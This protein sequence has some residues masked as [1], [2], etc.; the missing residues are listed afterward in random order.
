MDSTDVAV[1]GAGPAGM[2][3]AA[4]AAIHG[5]SVVLL[6]EQRAAGGQ[7]YRAVEAAAGPRGTLLGKDYREGLKLTVALANVA[8]D[9]RRDATVWRL[10]PDGTL[11]YSINGTARLLRARRII[12]ATG[13]LERPVPIPGWTLPGVMTAGA[14][15]I[16]MKE[17]GLVPER[18]VI[19]GCGPLLYL[20]AWQMIR[21]GRPPHALVETQRSED[22]LRAG[23]YTAGALRGRQTLIKGLSLLVDIRRAGV[24]RHTGATTLRVE[25]DGQAEALSFRAGGRE[26]RISCATVLLH[27]GVVPN[28]QA[29]RS[30]G[31][32]HVW[33]DLQRCFKP[34]TDAWG[35]TALET[36]F[37]AGDGAGI[38][39][40]QAAVHTGRLAALEVAR[41]L[42][43]IDTATRDRLARPERR[44]LA[45]ERAVRPFLDAAY[46]PAPETLA[47]RDDTVIVCRCEEVT[48]GDIRRYASLGCR[49][50]NQTKALGRCGMG[51]CQGRY[52]GLT[53]TELLS[54]VTGLTPAETGAYR[55]RTPL[56]PITL[57]ELAALAETERL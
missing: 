33:D 51:P 48:A 34:V 37:A 14:A 11:A 4:C 22:L 57:G 2:A 5:L 27:Q 3:A 35:Q 45:R 21:A 9:H 50:P 32:P 40:A 42:E 47:P 23:R 41:R 38:A 19:A 28:T 49:G 30:L 43:A 15:Q 54:E 26:H 1:I 10:D 36:V 13:A 8:V 24:P 20:L 18:A 7:V 52:C 31:L 17:S 25:G 12:L 55:I 56:K 16:L 44:G 46:P 29:T 39:G 53:V 6:D